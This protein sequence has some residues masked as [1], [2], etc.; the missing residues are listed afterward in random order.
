[1]AKLF[2]YRAINNA[3]GDPCILIQLSRLKR[4]LLLDLGDIRRISFSEILKISDIF[5]THT[6]IDHFI[7]FDQV[8]RAILRRQEPIRIFGPENIIEAVEGKLR[9][10]TWN[11]VEDYP[12]KIETYGIKNNKEMSF[13][14]FSASKGFKKEEKGIIGI[15]NNIILNDSLFK[16][17]ATVLSHGIPVIAYSIQEEYHIN[18]NKVELEKRGLQIGPWLGE[19]KKLVKTHYK[20]DPHKILKPKNKNLKLTVETPKGTIPIEE[21]F[22]LLII[23]KG[24]KISYVMDVAPKEE[25]IKKLIN[26]LRHSDILFCEAYFLHKDIDRALQRNHLTAKIVGEIARKAKVREVKI[27]HISP[28]YIENPQEVYKEV[29]RSR[30]GILHQ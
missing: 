3:F 21:V 1:M 18:I 30:Q 2:H 16:V 26:F 29:E 12:L 17:K 10:Y 20:F 23:T 9:G 22:P 19:L 7:G 14:V 25:N 5:V 28:K 15:K 11:L 4:A 8:I 27:L 6:H 13:A 24:E